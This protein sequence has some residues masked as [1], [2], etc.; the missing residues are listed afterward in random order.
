MDGM[1]VY[2][3]V[4]EPIGSNMF[5]IIKNQ[6]AFVVDPHVSL[7]ADELLNQAGVKQVCI[8][9]T[10]EH[11]DHISGVNHFREYWECIVIGNATTKECLPNPRKNLSAYFKSMFFNKDEETI[12][13]AENV[14]SEEFCCEAEIGFEREYRFQWNDCDVQLIETPGHS[15]GSICILI[16]G[17]YIFTGDSLVDGA[18]I[19]TRLPGGSKKD[20]MSIT[21]P[22]LEALS[23]DMI[24]FPGHGMEGKLCDFEIA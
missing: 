18:S 15:K 8:L 11:Y 24:V 21:K 1:Q 23:K 20:Y 7:E 14:F 13:M 4:L 6:M 19:I 5:I 12:R 17:T 3:Y 9:L 16:N 10:H 2:K 22:F